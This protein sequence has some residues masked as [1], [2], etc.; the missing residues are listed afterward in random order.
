MK[1]EADKIRYTS[2]ELR[3]LREIPING[4]MISTTEIA[5]RVYPADRTPRYARQSV[6]GALNSLIDKS[7]ENEEPWEI[8]KAKR[9]GS[10]PSYFW[11]KPREKSS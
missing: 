9:R 6:L 7:D 2:F 5:G 11:R 10:Q 3:I 8:F 1:D 4:E